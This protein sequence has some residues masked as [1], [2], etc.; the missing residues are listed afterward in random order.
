MPNNQ[1]LSARVF[2]NHDV[3]AMSPF[4]VEDAGYAAHYAQRALRRREALNSLQT[5]VFNR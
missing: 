5:G 1:T 2:F 4:P 3:K